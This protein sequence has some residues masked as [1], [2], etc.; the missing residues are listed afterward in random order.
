VVFNRINENKRTIGNEK[1][2][3]DRQKKEVRSSLEGEIP[4]QKERR[5]RVGK[6]K[7]ELTSRE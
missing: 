4:N 2:R 6:Q 7:T 3:I 5:R 1:K